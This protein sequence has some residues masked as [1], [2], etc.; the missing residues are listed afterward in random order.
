MVYNSC[1]QHT[2]KHKIK[3]LRFLETG[4]GYNFPLEAGS[5]HNFPLKDRLEYIFSP[6]ARVEISKP[7]K[8]RKREWSINLPSKQER[9][10]I[11]PLK[12]RGEHNS[13]SGGNIR[14]AQ[15]MFK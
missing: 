12:T 3:V 9:G 2:Q 4:S 8:T 6:K 5:G 1:P 10:T 7:L 13:S 15:L 14:K 11:F